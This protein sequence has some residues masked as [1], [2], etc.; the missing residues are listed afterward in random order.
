MPPAF[1][2]LYARHDGGSWL[3]GDLVLFPLVREHD[4]TVARASTTYRGWEWPVPEELVLIGTGGGGDPIGLWVPAATPGRPLVVGVG[5]VFEPGC[6]GILGEDLDS[7]LRAWTAYH[8]LLP[9]REEVTAALDA[10]ELP[11]RLRADDPDDETF[12][13][14]GE[15]AS[16]TIPRS[17][18]DPYQARLT[19]DDVR[20]FA[21]DR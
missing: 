2:E 5:S 6:L 13:L 17:L 15:W 9:D 11:R 16:P 1:R 4:L 21:S 20:R 12:A 10:L 14:V 18:R 19:A 3:A 7:F 8:L